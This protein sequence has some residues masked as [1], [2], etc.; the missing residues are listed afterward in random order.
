MTQLSIDKFGVAAKLRSG[1]S[2]TGTYSSYNYNNSG[3]GG[4]VFSANTSAEFWYD[5]NALTLY[6]PYIQ[7]NSLT[8]NYTGSLTG[9]KSVVSDS[10]G[11]L[12]AITGATSGIQGNTSPEFKYD[13]TGTTLYVPLI[14]SSGITLTGLTSSGSTNY[15]VSDSKGNLHI[16]NVVGVTENVPVAKV[17]GGTRTLQFVNGLYVG[18]SDS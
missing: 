6:V 3:A 10:N 2:N 18:Y 1:K 17:G 15:I 8:V 12:Y 9:W 4:V 16:T 14:I 5:P 13:Q 11:K 7:L